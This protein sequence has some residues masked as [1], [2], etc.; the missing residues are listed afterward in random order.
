MKLW[1]GRFTKET[2]QLVHNFNASISFD[3]KFYHQDIEGSIAH[4][5]MLA[6]QG[7]LTEEDKDKIVKGLMEI[8][9]D[10]ESGALVI[11]GE[12][13]DIHSFVEAVLT[14][15]IGE[16]GKRLHTGRSRNDQVA[17]DM[18]LYTRDEIDELTLLMEGLL[19]ELLKLM[20][21]NLDTYMPGFTHLQKAQPITLAHHLGAYFEMFDRDHS[22]LHDI[23]KRMNYCPLGSGALAGTTYPLDREYTAELLGFAGPTLNSM[24]SVADRDYLIELLSALSTISMHLSRFCEE[25]IIWN[26]NEYRFVEIDDS[27]ST[28]SSIMPQKKNPDIAELIR[29]KTGRV[30]GALVSLLT[31]MKGIPLAYNKDMQEDKELAFDAIDTVKGCL[32]LFTGMIS[33]MTFRKD[34]M[35]A[36]AK[37]GFTNATDAADYLVNHGVAFRDA[38]GIVGQLVLFCIEKGIALDDMSLEEYKAIS[39]VFEEDIYDAISL[40][41]CVEKRMTIGAPGQEAMKRVIEIYKKKLEK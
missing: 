34:V 37:N 16:A 33:T 1:G 23:K 40:K 24:D 6:K 27:Y 15:R 41:T 32:A 31:T 8:R 19:S 14:E 20:E 25:I 2:N 29:G 36:S 12:H 26:T 39:P 5:K 11:T 4:V 28:G 35:E 9:E 38:H 13:E 17:L 10:L 21:E 18:K 7:L 3:Q 22:R 30:Y